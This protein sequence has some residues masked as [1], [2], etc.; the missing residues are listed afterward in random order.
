MF[1]ARPVALAGTSFD[2]MLQRTD[3]PVVVDFWAPWCGPC[4][5][6][7]PTYE[8]ACARL[9]PRARLAKLDTEA[10]PAI[11]QRHAIRSIPTLAIFRGG[12]EVARTSGALPL[13]DL[14]R[15]VEPHL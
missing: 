8:Q 5:S 4:R 2:A 9:E 14:L 6:F 13:A 7:A 10:E 15:L 12:Q 1:D 11:A 3:L